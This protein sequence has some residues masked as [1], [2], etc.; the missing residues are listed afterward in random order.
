MS[1]VITI[2][3][4]EDNPQL[5]RKRKASESIQFNRW[6]K[7]NEISLVHS[8]LNSFLHL[9][10]AHY[11]P[12]WLRF[13]QLISSIILARLRYLH[14]LALSSRSSLEDAPSCSKAGLI[15]GMNKENPFEHLL[16]GRSA[17][18][19]DR[20]ALHHGQ[21]HDLRCDQLL[22]SLVFGESV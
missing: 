21:A 16:F 14:S 11:L 20:H 18:W 15:S 10:A 4:T 8:H 22:Y 13:R 7:T 1:L 17:R 9:I 19:I 6:L 5:K 2:S 12:F 3:S